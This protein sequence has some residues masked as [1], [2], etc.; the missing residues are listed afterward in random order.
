MAV[1]RDAEDLINIGAYVAGTN[2]NI[3]RAIKV[4]EPIKS[5]LQQDVYEVDTFEETVER[6]LAL[7]ST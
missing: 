7:S 3:D 5:F 2:E 6:L 4:I 1:Y